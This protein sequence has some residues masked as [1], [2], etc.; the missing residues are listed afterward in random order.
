M[1]KSLYVQTALKWS[2]QGRLYQVEYDLEAVNQG[3][4]LIT[5]KSKNHVF[6]AGFKSATNKELSYFP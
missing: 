6:I 3:N 2:P 1:Q 5:K 4:L